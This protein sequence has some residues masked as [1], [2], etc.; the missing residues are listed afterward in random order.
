M[1]I[2]Q[3]M[4][5]LECMATSQVDQVNSKARDWLNRQLEESPLCLAGT[6]AVL[7]NDFTTIRDAPDE[8]V[9]VVVDIAVNQIMQ[10]CLERIAETRKGDA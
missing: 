6:L 4:R 7:K 5:K 3:Y 8:I 2:D 9:Q 1:D 10:M